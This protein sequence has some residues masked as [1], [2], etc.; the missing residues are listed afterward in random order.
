MRFFDDAEMGGKVAEGAG[1]SEKT[2]MAVA[3]A[4]GV[5]GGNI[6]AAEMVALGSLSHKKDDDNINHTDNLDARSER[7]WS[8]WT[9]RSVLPTLLNQFAALSVAIL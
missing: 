1:D 4:D 9:K 3:K 5:G 2:G 8:G 7:A 6:S